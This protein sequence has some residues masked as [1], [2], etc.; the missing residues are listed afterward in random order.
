MDFN[1]YH[2]INN[3]EYVTRMLDYKDPIFKLELDPAQAGKTYLLVCVCV[4]LFLEGCHLLPN[5]IEA[6]VYSRPETNR[7]NNYPHDG[8]T[9]LNTHD[10]RYLDNLG[11]R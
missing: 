6:T 2:K 4:S 11:Y 9:D 3:R 5:F 8:P 7:Y 1:R 10:S